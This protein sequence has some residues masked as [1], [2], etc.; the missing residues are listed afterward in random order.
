MYRGTTPTFVFELDTTT[1]DLSSMVQIW[2]TIQDGNKV[3]HTWDISKVTIDNDNKTISLYL[4]QEETFAMA[5]GV[6]HVQIR[7]LTDED[8]ALTTTIEIVNL[9]NVIKGGIIQ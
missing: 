1:L 2:V 3:K 6:G 4:S 7:M 9:N 8:V 5:A